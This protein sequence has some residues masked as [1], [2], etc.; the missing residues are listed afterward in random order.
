[1]I[2][3]FYRPFR[4]SNLCII[5]ALC[6]RA[7]LAE[8]QT[9]A[10]G[11]EDAQNNFDLTKQPFG[12]GLD[13]TWVRLNWWEGNERFTFWAKWAM[14]RDWRRR[15]VIAEYNDLRIR[16][17]AILRNDFLP[18]AI[19][20]EM[21]LDMQK[22]PRC[23][24]PRYVRNICQIT[25]RKRGNVTRYRLSRFVFRDMADHG[26]LSGVAMI[27]MWMLSSFFLTDLAR[28]ASLTFLHVPKSVH[29]PSTS[30]PFTSEVSSVAG[31]LMGLN[32]DAPKEWLNSGDLFQRAEAMVVFDIVAP[33]HL[34]PNLKSLKTYRLNE[35][36]T[37]E[38]STLWLEIQKTFSENDPTLIESSML[39]Q[40]KSVRN[41]VPDLYL[42]NFESLLWI[43]EQQHTATNSQEVQDAIA[44]IETLIKKLTDTFKNVYDDNCIVLMVSSSGARSRKPRQLSMSDKEPQNSYTRYSFYSQDYAVTF[45]IIFWLMFSFIITIMFIGVGMWTMSPG[46]DSLIYQ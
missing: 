30:T 7:D 15:Q 42:F 35:D 27:C 18:M 14:R 43:V 32:T 40:N 26:K 39:E 19:R 16:M 9:I 4:P 45:N 1:M 17:K 2:S 34:K 28:C 22:L 10:T 3:V 6:S 13:A 12:Y 37:P 8:Q 38:F 11:V 33:D 24:F 21:K 46:R 20:Q 25:G 36:S 41:G 29:L 44:K 5:R 31:T 23:C